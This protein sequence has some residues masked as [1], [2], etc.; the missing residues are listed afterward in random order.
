MGRLRLVAVECNYKEI[1]RHLM[2]KFI[3]RLND[4]DMLAKLIRNLTKAKKSTAVTSEQVL[5]WIKRVEAQKVQLTIIT[6]LNET[7]EFDKIKTIKGG[8]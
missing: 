3:H 6:R 1:D 4:N 8:Q 5:V 2:E 7:K